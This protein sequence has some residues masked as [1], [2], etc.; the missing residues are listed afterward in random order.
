M[1]AWVCVGVFVCVCVVCVSG[2]CVL[3]GVCVGCLCGRL[4][5]LCGCVCC[6]VLVWVRGF[7][8]VGVWF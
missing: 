6:C 5:G 1:C 2:V 8:L 3:V 7:E 4:Q